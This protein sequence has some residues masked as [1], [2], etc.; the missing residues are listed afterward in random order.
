MPMC[1]MRA[2]WWCLGFE[3]EDEERGMTLYAHVG[4][5]PIV[6]VRG[7]KMGERQKLQ[8]GTWKK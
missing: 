6:V 1:V 8:V 2:C 5:V 3:R 4:K 7:K